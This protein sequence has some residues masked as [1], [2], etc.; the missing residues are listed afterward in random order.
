MNLYLFVRQQLES[1][2]HLKWRTVASHDKR[3]HYIASN[4]DRD[5][6]LQTAECVIM[7]WERSMCP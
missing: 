5:R 4:E 6:E 1:S 7:T 2:T 3:C